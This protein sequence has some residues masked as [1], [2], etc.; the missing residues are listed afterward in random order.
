MN[1]KGWEAL[2]E[3]SK[4]IYKIT[5]LPIAVYDTDMGIIFGYPGSCPL[6]S[7]IVNYPTVISKC[8]QC[9]IEGIK[10]CNETGKSYI[11]KCHLGLLE[12]I[13]PIYENNKIV[14]YLKTGQ[15]LPEENYQTCCENL[16]KLANECKQLD[17]DKCIEL[18]DKTTN[19]DIEFIEAITDI[20][21]MCANQLFVSENINFGIHE[22]AIKLKH[23]VH[24]NFTKPGIC[25]DIVCDE[26][27]ISK[28][29]CS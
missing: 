3:F 2:N 7:Y 13:V 10:I 25:T 17:Y 9:D 14:G 8:I 29:F 12:A 24:E 5:K 26:L 11:Y 28:S 18:L 6:C 4:K 27:F 23:Y 21:Q 19:A 16:K 15:G 20:F 22:L 1:Q